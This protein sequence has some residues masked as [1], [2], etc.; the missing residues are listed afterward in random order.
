MAVLRGSAFFRVEVPLLVSPAGVDIVQVRYDSVFRVEGLPRTGGATEMR[1][2]AYR[3]TSLIRERP[4]LGP[5]RGPMP[6]VLGRSQRGGHFLMSE[7]S[8]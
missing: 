8:L 4:P 3:G 1:L 2:R 7:V 6:R 5:Y